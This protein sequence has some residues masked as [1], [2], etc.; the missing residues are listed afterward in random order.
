M[1]GFGVH[2]ILP[3]LRVKVTAL[4]QHGKPILYQHLLI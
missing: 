3:A 1:A 4:H 2:N